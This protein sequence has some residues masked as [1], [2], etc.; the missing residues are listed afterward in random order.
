MI[1]RIRD[2]LKQIDVPVLYHLVV[3]QEA[4]TLAEGGRCI[5]VNN[6][7]EAKYNLPYVAWCLMLALYFLSYLRLVVNAGRPRR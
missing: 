2:V 6:V 5:V 4:V 7:G 3:A 1:K